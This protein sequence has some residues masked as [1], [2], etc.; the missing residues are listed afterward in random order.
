MH[1][2]LS[3]FLCQLEIKLVDGIVYKAVVEDD[4]PLTPS[5]SFFIKDNRIQIQ[6]DPVA[7]LLTV[8]NN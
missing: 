8:F 3:I 2:V 4:W 1:I 6:T 7:Q 5:L